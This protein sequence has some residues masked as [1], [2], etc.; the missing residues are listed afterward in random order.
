LDNDSMF[1]RNF[2]DYPS[3]SVKVVTDEM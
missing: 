2:M 1:I 3:T